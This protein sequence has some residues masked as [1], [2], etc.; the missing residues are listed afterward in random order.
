[1]RGGLG[2]EFSRGVIGNM[3]QIGIVLPGR[4]ELGKPIRG[5]ARRVF[6]GGDIGSPPIAVR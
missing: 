4:T 2:A 1:M 5:N 6:D 3:S